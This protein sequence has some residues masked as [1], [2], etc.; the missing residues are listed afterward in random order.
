MRKRGI[1][2]RCRRRGVSVK[3]YE[4]LHA[5]HGGAGSPAYT[6][7]NFSLPAQRNSVSTPV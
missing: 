3:D 5:M 6:K 7:L 4:S 2:P 1:L